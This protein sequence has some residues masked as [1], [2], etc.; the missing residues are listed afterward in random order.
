MVSIAPAFGIQLWRWGAKPRLLNSPDR[1]K[2]EPDLLLQLA[3]HS[4]D[5]KNLPDEAIEHLLQRVQEGAL[6][7]RDLLEAKALAATVR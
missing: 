2:Y 7:T 6:M 4:V 5:P 1:T 3:K